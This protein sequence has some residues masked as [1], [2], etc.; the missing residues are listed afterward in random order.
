MLEE[1]SKADVGPGA[2]D[3]GAGLT[4]G[5]KFLIAA[6]EGCSRSQLV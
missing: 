4:S 6:A 1:G 5:G 2:P 3:L